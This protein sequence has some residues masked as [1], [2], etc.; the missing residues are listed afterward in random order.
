MRRVSL[1]AS[2]FQVTHDKLC[3]SM[4][5]QRVSFRKDS[6]FST[7]LLIQF[8]LLEEM[9]QQKMKKVPV[10]MLITE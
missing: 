3:F 1:C 5:F 8:F 10:S 9:L 6:S 2:L 7:Q 4:D